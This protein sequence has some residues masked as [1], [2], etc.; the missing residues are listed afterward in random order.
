[1]WLAGASLAAI[2][3]AARLA[4]YVVGLPLLPPSAEDI[5]AD[6]MHSSFLPDV[7]M[8]GEE[9]HYFASMEARSLWPFWRFVL[10]LTVFSTVPLVV[11]TVWLWLHRPPTCPHCG[12]SPV[13]P[14]LT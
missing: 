4:A 8:S 14:R 6:E 3:V 7:A 11:M 12:G 10:M 2:G 9:R 1:M 5:L 13:P